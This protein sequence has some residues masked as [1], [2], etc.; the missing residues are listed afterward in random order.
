MKDHLSIKEFAS[1][2]GIETTTLRYWDEIG[3]FS[4][5]A[6]GSDNKYRY[7]S[8]EQIIAVNFI[9]VLSRLNVPLKTISEMKTTRTPETI[10]D[11][12]DVQE[13]LLDMEMRRLRE[14]YSVIHM[15]RELIK[16]GIRADESKIAVVHQPE[17]SLIVGP[18]TNFRENE[19][20]YEPFTRFCMQSTDLRI[21][22]SYPIGGLHH[23]MERFIKAPDQ[24]DNFFSA[25][26]MGNV[27]KPEGNY[28]VAYTRGFYGEFGDVAAKMA[29]YA[30]THSLVCVGPVYVVYMHEEICLRNTADYLAR[31]SVAVV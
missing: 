3:L 8:P 11:L 1:L 2:S 6:R 25:D 27:K 19:S 23:N 29:E 18:D 16:D 30:K 22:L 4:P 28:L 17:R 15:R 26:P 20:F 14:C 12:I 5:A 24:P 9:T 13:Q 21:N 31:I 10:M 7:Y